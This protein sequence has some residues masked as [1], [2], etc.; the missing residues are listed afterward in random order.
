MRL[1]HSS[2]SRREEVIPTSCPVSQFL[3]FAQILEVFPN[4]GK[5]ENQKHLISQQLNNSIVFDP[6]KVI[7]YH[8]PYKMA[9][10]EIEGMFEGV[11]PDYYCVVKDKKEDFY[12]V[13][14]LEDHPSSFLLDKSYQQYL[15]PGRKHGQDS[16]VIIQPPER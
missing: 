6:Y 13:I 12:W 4:M 14:N 7:N 16:F 15:S 11:L 3:S 2:R 8:K 5:S 10:E 9:F 1:F